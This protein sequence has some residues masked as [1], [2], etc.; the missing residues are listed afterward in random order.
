[1]AARAFTVLSCV[2][3]FIS[4]GLGQA[5][6]VELVVCTCLTKESPADAFVVIGASF[7]HIYSSKA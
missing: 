7:R 4:K 5:A 2:S 3:R 1:M 6:V